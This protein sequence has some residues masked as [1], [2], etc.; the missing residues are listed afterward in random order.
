MI[1]GSNGL[2]KQVT[3]AEEGSLEL[4]REKGNGNLGVGGCGLAPRRES[5]LNL[6]FD[7]SYF[8]TKIEKCQVK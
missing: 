2:R 7:R 8:N 4:R 3:E 6:A 5:S 1:S